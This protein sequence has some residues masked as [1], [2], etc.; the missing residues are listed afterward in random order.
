MISYLSQEQKI[1]I[2]FR[3]IARRLNKKTE[4][5]L[6][7]KILNVLD[8]ER[9]ELTNQCFILRKFKI[10]ALKA[11]YESNKN[12]LINFAYIFLLF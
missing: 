7:I 6:D 3:K 1:I 9:A 10:I 11:S 5:R 12:I 8:Y 4:L 2:K